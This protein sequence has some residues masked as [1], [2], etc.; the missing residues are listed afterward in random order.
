MA[1]K[2]ILPHCCGRLKGARAIVTGVWR[3]ENLALWSK[4]C[5]HAQYLATAHQ[6][7][8]IQAQPLS[9]PV[10]EQEVLDP[11]LNEVR[12][13]H[14]T[15]RQ[16]ADKIIRTGFDPSLAAEK[17]KFGLGCY[18]TPEMCKAAQYTEKVGELYLLY[19]RVV[20]GDPYY[21]HDTLVGQSRPPSRCLE[22]PASNTTPQHVSTDLPSTASPNNYPAASVDVPVPLDSVVVNTSKSSEGRKQQMHREF[23]VHCGAQAYPE[24]LVKISLA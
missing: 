15:T 3:V 2:P 18:F 24:Y 1:S 4:Y 11:A 10:R 21:A 12:A 6:Q 19:C 16:A 8:G 22:L 23:V 14:G 5:A 17:A 7:L 20:L 13:W 9:P